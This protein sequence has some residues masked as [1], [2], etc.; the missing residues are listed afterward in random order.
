LSNEIGSLNPSIKFN[1]V[2]GVVEF[3][4]QHFD[5]AKSLLSFVVV[6]VLIQ[7]ISSCQ[8]TKSSPFQRD[9]TTAYK[10]YVRGDYATA[11]KYYKIVATTRNPRQFHAQLFVAGMY[12]DGR[13]VAKDIDKVFYWTK[14]AAD[15]GH[16]NAIYNMGKINRDIRKDYTKAIMW[17][18]RAA[19]TGPSKAAIESAMVIGAMYVMGQG[20]DKDLL[21]ARKWFQSA[22][23]LGHKRGSAFVRWMD[24]RIAKGEQTSNDPEKVSSLEGIK[25]VTSSDIIEGKP[26]SIHEAKSVCKDLGFSPKTEK[27]GECVLA[28]VK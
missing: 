17:Y 21:E 28:L 7:L 3:F 15:G 23:D 5:G 19:S 9:E 25:E 6:A 8:T 13:G 26:A 27:F 18:K 1:G 16:V 22:N 14:R 12:F 2:F 20:V 11:L 24:V 4:K 10:A